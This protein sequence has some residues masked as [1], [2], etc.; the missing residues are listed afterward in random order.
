VHKQKPEDFPV[1]TVKKAAV[2]KKP[3]K[4]GKKKPGV[5]ATTQPK[6]QNRAEVASVDLEAKFDEKT[7]LKTGKIKP[8]ASQSNVCI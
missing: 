7:V 1:S 4:A 3:A 8:A 5:K 2:N 6:P